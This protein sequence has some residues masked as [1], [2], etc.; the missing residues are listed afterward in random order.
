LTAAPLATILLA[1]LAPAPASAAAS[2]VPLAPEGHARDQPYEVVLAPARG[3]AGSFDSSIVFEV[4]GA[5][6]GQEPLTENPGALFYFTE[7]ADGLT[8][9]PSQ[10]VVVVVGLIVTSSAVT[11]ISIDG[12]A[13]I[14]TIPVSGPP[15]EV[16]SVLYEVPG[17]TLRAVRERRV[18]MQVTPFG[19]DSQPLVGLPST[20]SPPPNPALET[21]TWESPA[22][23]ARGVCQLK[24]DRFQGLAALSGSTISVL[25][26]LTGALGEPY[27]TCATTIYSYHGQEPLYASVVL[28][29]THPGQTP[30]AIPALSPVEGR[31]GTFQ[32]RALGG[33]LDPMGVGLFAGVVRLAL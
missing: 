31:P 8:S 15:Y 20:Q 16:R 17:V 25:R 10:S 32:S 13:P 23:A 3:T 12:G 1:A 22:P 6:S 19:A 18:R 28:D 24:A 27:L 11:S 29:A 2:V 33:Y 30:A 4:P 9:T 26:P 7:R 14:P 21:R 5:F